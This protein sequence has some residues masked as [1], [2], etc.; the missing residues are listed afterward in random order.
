MEVGKLS[1][2]SVIGRASHGANKTS[3][4]FTSTAFQNAR[5]LHSVS[6]TNN[7][8]SSLWVVVILGSTIPD[9]S[10]TTISLTPLFVLPSETATLPVSWDSGPS[11]VPTDA[12]FTVLIL[13]SIGGD[14][15]HADIDEAELS[16]VLV[17]YAP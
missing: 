7:T 6:I 4:I 15:S 8:G 14:V 5:T 16:S 17:T 13:D 2:P 11:G 3:V 1:Y 9:E 10:T 12:G